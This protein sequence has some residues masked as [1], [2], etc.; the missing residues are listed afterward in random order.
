MLQKSN[1]YKSNYRISFLIF[2]FFVK[3]M[4]KNLKSNKMTKN[5]K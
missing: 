5:F 2:S 4:G 3:K 1:I